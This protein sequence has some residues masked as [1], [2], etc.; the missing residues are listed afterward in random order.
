[1]RSTST[2][3]ARR[4]SRGKSTVGGR[5]RSFLR[6]RRRRKRRRRSS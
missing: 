4:R 1:M 5:S 3:G 6:R 2:P